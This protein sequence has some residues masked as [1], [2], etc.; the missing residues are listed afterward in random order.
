MAV[1][2]RSGQRRLIQSDPKL[3]RTTIA[4]W[5]P[6]WSRARRAAGALPPRPLLPAARRPRAG[7][8]RPA[9][10]PADRAPYANGARRS[11]ADPEAP[12]S[13]RSMRRRARC[14]CGI[15]HRRAVPRRP[16]L[17]A[18]AR[19]PV[20]Q[21]RPRRALDDLDKDG[22]RHPGGAILPATTRSSSRCI[23]VEVNLRLGKAFFEIGSI[24]RS[25]KWYVRAWISLLELMSDPG[26]RQGGSRARELARRR[27]ARPRARQARLEL[28]LE[29]AVPEMCEADARLA[30]GALAADIL[31]RISQVLVVIRLEDDSA[32]TCLRHAAELDRR[33]LLAQT[34]LLLCRLRKHYPE[35]EFMVADPTGVLVVGA[36]ES[37]RP[38]APRST[39]C[40]SAS[41]RSGGHDRPAGPP[42]ASR[43]R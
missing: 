36:S 20:S 39:S 9:Q 7:I 21:P 35:F 32:L 10:G 34:G 11:P 42:S 13:A 14:A 43:V 28:F 6:L 23:P 33:N 24:K 31:A 3:A 30:Y 26:H 4:P 38:S 27:Q 29:T 18:G 16:R 40:S 19:A 12:A 1:L 22:V 25:L 17:L 41:R 5:C 8:Q 2:G 37:I 15:S